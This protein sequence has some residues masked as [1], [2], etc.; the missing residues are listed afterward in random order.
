MKEGF[1][2]SER[3]WREVRKQGELSS[4]LERSDRRGGSCCVGGGKFGNKGNH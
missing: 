3:I 2:N 4:R 1:L